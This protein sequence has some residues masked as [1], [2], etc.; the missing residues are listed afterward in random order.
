[1]IVEICF[2]YID[3]SSNISSGLC[4]IL[5]LGTV[6]LDFVSDT[7]IIAYF[8][9]Y[10]NTQN[11][12]ISMLFISFIA[13]NLYVLYSRNTSINLT[14][15]DDKVRG[16]QWHNRTSEYYLV[17]VKQ[18]HEVEFRDSLR[19]EKKRHAEPKAQRVIPFGIH[20]DGRADGSWELAELLYLVKCST[21]SFGSMFRDE[22]IK[23]IKDKY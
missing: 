22:L 14:M 12:V 20:R 9:G 2:K 21:E 23:K 13:R 17:S 5:C 3:Y 16:E 10:G 15:S 1:M 19:R 18:R 7:N 4:L 6:S 8:N 11:A